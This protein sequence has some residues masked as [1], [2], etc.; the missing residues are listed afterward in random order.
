ML[1][2]HYLTVLAPSCN[3]VPNQQG[4]VGTSR[5]GRDKRRRRRRSA[6]SLP[7]HGNDDELH[8]QGASSHWGI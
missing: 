7:K 6:P 1:N 2:Q 3:L 5:C 4:K 8:P